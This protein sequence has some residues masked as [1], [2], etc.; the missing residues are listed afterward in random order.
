MPVSPRVFISYS[1]ESPEHKN[2][3][4]AFASRLVREGVDATLDQWERE[5]P[6]G[7]WPLWMEQHIAHSDFVILVCTDIYCRRVEMPLEQQAGAGVFW[8]AN[9]IRNRLYS[10]KGVDKRFLPAH[11]GEANP[12]QIPEM[13]HGRSSYQIDTPEGYIALYRRLTG[14]PEVERPELGQIVVLPSISSTRDQVQ[15]D[16]SEVTLSAPASFTKLHPLVRFHASEFRSLR[17]DQPT[18][19]RF[20][21]YLSVPVKICWIDYEGNCDWSNVGT[22]EPGG[23]RLMQSYVT[24]PFIAATAE[25]QTIA[26]FE[27]GPDPGIAA[28]TNELVAEAGILDTTP[29]IKLQAMARFDESQFRSE[30]AE[31]LTWVRFDNYLR[32]PVSV[33]WL[34]F[35][36]KRQPS[37]VIDP[38]RSAQVQVSVGYPWV[39]TKAEGDSAGQALALFVAS[40]EPGIAEIT[41]KLAARIRHQGA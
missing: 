22:L 10:S 13:L 6:P 3:V 25:G 5:D 8:E 34:D 26:L 31:E 40:D 17:Y 16:E 11:F 15:A 27:P 23:S 7:G 36:G 28:V 24:H 32:E 41:E 4:L 39:V 38:G 12:D 21:N 20:D 29:Y 18:L 9:L 33:Y 19:I 2:R 35:D 14:Q 1:H 37:G 30:P